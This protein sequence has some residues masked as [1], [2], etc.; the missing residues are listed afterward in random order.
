MES[1]V[2]EFPFCL[3]WANQTWSGIWH[4]N[5]HD[6][7]IKQT[8]PGE[9]DFVA[10]FNYVRQAFEDN[11][12]LKVNGKPIFLVYA[13]D[14]IPD[15][16]MFSMLWRGLAVKTGLPGLYLV[17]M[18]NNP[19]E[20]MIGV[21]DAITPNSPADFLRLNNENVLK[22]G[23]RAVLKK[24]V[25][26]EGLSYIFGSLAPPARYKYSEVVD[27]VLANLME[28]YKKIPAVL[29]NWDNTP[30]SGFSGM[31]CDDCTP[32]LYKKF[33][34]GAVKF[35]QDEEEPERIIFIRAWNEWAEGNYLEPDQRFGS[36]YLDAT[37]SVLR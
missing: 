28:N 2:P 13:P 29:T 27:V 23:L 33:L 32:E 12:Y 7:L 10:H 21:F 36:A 17:G 18:S 15:L 14:D 30:R 4:G 35:V 24:Y 5:P 25:K 3:A 19:S 1:G 8:Y 16:K 11:R 20:E 31:V 9:D 34:R 26:Y 37:R 22:R 6:V